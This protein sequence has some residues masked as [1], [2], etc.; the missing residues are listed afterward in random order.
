[1]ENPVIAPFENTLKKNKNKAWLQHNN[2]DPLSLQ[3]LN[4]NQL[5]RNRALKI[6][7]S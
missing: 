4:D 2:I 1:M 7:I 3:N 6:L 5:I